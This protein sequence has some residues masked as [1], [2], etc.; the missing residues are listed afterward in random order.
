MNMNSLIVDMTNRL[1]DM[2]RK[3]IDRKKLKEGK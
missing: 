1:S 3:V 2:E